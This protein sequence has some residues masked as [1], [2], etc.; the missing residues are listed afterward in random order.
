MFKKIYQS[1]ILVCLFILAMQYVHVATAK[2]QPEIRDQLGKIVQEVVN[3]TTCHGENLEGSTSMKTSALS[4][5]KQAYLIQR[6]QEFQHQAQL[7]QDAEDKPE[8][9]HPQREN[10]IMTRVAKQLSAYQVKRV[11]A[12]IAGLNPKYEKNY[13]ELDPELIAL[14][15]KII[16]LG[17]PDRKIPSCQTCHGRN[18][19]GASWNKESKATPMLSMHN[20]VYLTKRLKQLHTLMEQDFDNDVYTEESTNIPA[21]HALAYKLEEDEINAIASYIV[22]KQGKKIYNP[23]AWTINFPA[24][25]YST[26]K[27]PRQLLWQHAQDNYQKQQK[28]LNLDDLFDNEDLEF[29]WQNPEIPNTPEGKLIKLGKFLFDNTDVLYGQYTTNSLRC[30]DCHLQHGTDRF[31][32]PVYNSVPKNPVFDKDKQMYTSL[33]NNIANCFMMSLN[34][35]SPNSQSK[36]MLALRSYIQWLGKSIPQNSI[37]KHKDVKYIKLP[38]DYTQDLDKVKYNRGQKIY[39]KKCAFCHGTNGEGEF[40]TT[41]VKG[42]KR[43]RYVFPALWGRYSYSWGSKMSQIDTAA[44]F[45]KYAMPMNGHKLTD[46]QA[47]DVALF[48]NSHE[49]P[50]DPRYLGS[51]NRTRDAFYNKILS[52]YGLKSFNEQYSGYTLGSMTKRRPPKGDKKPDFTH[53]YSPKK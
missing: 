23:D 16:T 1:F 34:G 2:T 3:C 15:K 39:E 17:L 18:L 12:F 40:D 36:P 20:K 38:T 47:W 49:R 13:I 31:A 45:I 9:D 19:N 6:L 24:R 28:H 26:Q 51:I 48:I 25:Q 30:A 4:G 5:Q 44:A 53:F 10:E 46:R 21:M 29:N 52:S 37:V 14:G 50:Q 32:L 42:K 35:V 11:S 43:L 22:S 8:I 41:I 7:N 27:L 33:T